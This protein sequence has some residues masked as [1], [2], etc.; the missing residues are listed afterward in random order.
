LNKI[1]KDD[2]GAE[3]FLKTASKDKKSAESFLLD[4]IYEEKEHLSGS[5]VQT[6]LAAVRSLHDFAEITPPLNWKKIAKAAPKASK[7]QDRPTSIDE[8]QK[9]FIPADLRLKFIISLLASSGGR[10][11]IFDYFALKDFKIIEVEDFSQGHLNPKK[12]DIA[13]LQIYRGEPESYTAFASSECVNLF[14]AY[15]EERTRSGEVLGP[16]SPLVRNPVTF[17]HPKEKKIKQTSSIAIASQLAYAWRKVGLAKREFKLAHGFRKFFKTSLESSGMKSITIERL[18]GHLS[19]LDSS[20]YRPSDETLAVEYAKFQSA[21]FIDPSL[22]LQSEK[23]AILKEARS[24]I[25]SESSR[26]QTLE[27]EVSELKSA[28]SDVT[29]ALKKIQKIE[30]EK[31]G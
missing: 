2:A 13:Q 6:F 29:E 16:D 8:I 4:W 9:A 3:A 14:H 20:Y 5:T 28:L 27:A 7:S 19:Q 17:K 12:I 23:D 22:S 11:G 24:A 18:L 21:L 31:K 25:S 10:V 1:F 30:A 26:V 15:C